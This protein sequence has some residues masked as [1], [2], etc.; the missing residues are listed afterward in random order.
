MGKLGTSIP[1]LSSASRHLGNHSVRDGRVHFSQYWAL[2]V[3]APLLQRRDTGGAAG[4]R[5]C[6]AVLQDGAAVRKQ[7]KPELNTN[8]LTSLISIGNL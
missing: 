7:N 3:R 1:V 6:M 8:Q 2:F 4:R 5:Y